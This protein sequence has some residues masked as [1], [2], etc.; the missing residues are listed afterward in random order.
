E[1]RGADPRRGTAQRCR[2]RRYRRRTRRGRSNGRAVLRLDR[3]RRFSGVAGRPRTTRG[4]GPRRRRF[5]MKAGD[6]MSRDIVSVGC[7]T[8]IAEAIRLMLDNQISG[9]PVIEAG[10]VV[11]ILTEG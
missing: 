6:I 3:R 8:T 2:R 5:P 4:G 9:L 1:G 10:K 7:D 11:G